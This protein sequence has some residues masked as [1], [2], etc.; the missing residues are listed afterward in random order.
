[1]NTETPRKKDKYFRLLVCVLAIL[2]LITAFTYTV[3]TI[4]KDQN[5]TK[6]LL[7]EA[8]MEIDQAKPTETATAPQTTEITPITTAPEERAIVSADLSKDKVTINNATA[9]VIDE[10]V[11]SAYEFEKH[12]FDTRPMIL[13][14]HSEPDAA[15]LP[16]GKASVSSSYSFK[17]PS[18]NVTTI[19][20]TVADVLASAGIASIHLTEPISDI[21]ATLEIYHLD[22]IIHKRTH[23]F[24]LFI[25][26]AP[27]ALNARLEVFCEFSFFAIS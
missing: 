9:N 24:A 3:F 23:L 16:E 22:L 26:K 10:A 13:I 25:K 27:F 1:M 11:L 12:L 19:G 15:Y 5:A 7:L 6:R 17:N 8:F 4:I 14:Y 18:E 21:K 2:A 20:N